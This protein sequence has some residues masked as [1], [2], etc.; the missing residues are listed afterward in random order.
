MTRRGW[1]LFSTM[2]VIWGIPYLL[3]K[4][5]GAEVSP[6]FLVF[7]RTAFGALLL[8]PIAAARGDLRGLVR[9]WKVLILYT[10]IEIGGPWLLLSDAETRVS[11]SFAALLVAAV[12]LVAAVLAWASRA[13]DR[14]DRS[15]V[16][17]L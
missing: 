9:H 17:G 8:V 3:I 13:D 15:R 11:S 12:P 10:V 1:I 4:V 5:A 7:F 6:V 14:V 2:A 16:I